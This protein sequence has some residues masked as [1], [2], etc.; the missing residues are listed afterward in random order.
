MGTKVIIS[1]L[2]ALALSTSASAN[3]ELKVNMYKL[4]NHMIQMQAAFIEGDKSKAIKAVNALEEESHKLFDKESDIKRMLPEDKRFKSRIA[5]TS[6]SMIQ[7]SI[8]TIKDS[9][10]GERR[11][12]AQNAYLDLQRAC[13]HCHNLVRDW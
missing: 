13:M 9:I 10:D 7:N 11:D 6:A 5:V 12:T 2:V 4:N 3:E 8:V 1:T